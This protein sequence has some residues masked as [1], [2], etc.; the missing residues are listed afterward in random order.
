MYE[1]AHKHLPLATG[2][3]YRCRS[4]SFLPL[5]RS[6]KQR[7]PYLIKL[8]VHSVYFLS[9][10]YI[11]LSHGYVLAIFL[12][13]ANVVAFFSSTMLLRMTPSFLLGT[14]LGSLLPWW[15]VSSAWLVF[16]FFLLPSLSPGVSVSFKFPQWQSQNT[17]SIGFNFI[18]S[19]FWT[20]VAPQMQ[21]FPKV[22]IVNI[23]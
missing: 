13:T 1:M 15:W 11:Y 12:F 19:N 5:V 6:I 18:N 22:K 4:L 20:A 17:C 10:R 2:S 8:A 21:K 23:C 14:Y 9:R 7:D 3:S 16:G